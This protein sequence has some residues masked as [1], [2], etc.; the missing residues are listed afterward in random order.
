M[1]YKINT[2]KPTTFINTNNNQI[3]DITECPAYKN[4]STNEAFTQEMCMTY[5][6]KTLEYNCRENLT[7][8][9]TYHIIGQ[10]ISIL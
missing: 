1:K 2:Q 3:K 6:K 8:G 7:N 10:E 5:M 9:K 4:I